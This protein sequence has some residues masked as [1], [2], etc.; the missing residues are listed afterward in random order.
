ME[1][2]FYKLERLT[3]ERTLAQKKLHDIEIEM[4]NLYNEMK[5]LVVS[6]KNRR[7]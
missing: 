3:T 1:S 5:E 6:K 4:E 7:E 2:L